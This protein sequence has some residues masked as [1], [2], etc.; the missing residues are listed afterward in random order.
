MRDHLAI[1]RFFRSP[2]RGWGALLGSAITAA[3]V[4]ITA[5]VGCGDSGVDG[6]PDSGDIADTGA[7]DGTVNPD[8]GDASDSGTATD[9]GLPIDA[10]TPDGGVTDD[11]LRPVLTGFR[12]EAAELDRLYFDSSEPIAASNTTGFFVSN[13]SATAI[14][15]NPGA[16]TGHYFTI[17][18]AFTFWDNNTIRYEGGGDVVDAYG[19]PLYEFT[20]QFV[21]N[22]IPEPAALADRYVSVSGGGAHDGTSEADAWTMAEAGSN[23]AAGQTVWMKAGDY[24]DRP[25]FIRNAGDASSPIKFIGYTTTPGDRPSLV[26]TQDTAFDAAEMPYIHSTSTSGSGINLAGQ[27]YIVLKNIQVAG[28]DHSLLANG[29]ITHVLIENVYLKDGA[30]YGFNLFAYDTHST[31]VKGCYVS[32]AGG[33]GIRVAGDHN[34]IDDMYASSRGAPSMDYYI[35]LYGGTIGLGN[36][37]RNSAVVRDPADSHTG[38]GISV[39]AGGRP[40]EHTLIEDCTLHEIGQGIEL[41]HHQ[42]RYTI[43]RNVVATGSR[44]RTANLVTFRDDTSYNTIEGCLADGIYVGVRF[45]MNAGEDLG[46]QPG[47][48]HNR[49]INTVFDNCKYGITIDGFGGTPLESTDNEFAHCTFYDMDT[50]FALPVDYGDSNTFTNCNFATITNESFN[51]GTPTTSYTY[52]NTWDLWAVV[53]GAGNISVDPMFVDAPGGDFTP[54]TADLNGGTE[55]DYVRYDFNGRERTSNR[56]RGAYETE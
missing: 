43:A 5:A 10:T 6:M 9:T 2:Q 19:N 18:E 12:V 32:N 31:R 34:L 55:L 11:G 53:P 44:A 21:D 36:I 41:R 20:L 39:K 14:T 29:N 4:L 54:G 56:T 28:Y 38:H 49:V 3:L 47:G 15:V 24:G 26:R 48:H 7:A 33:A 13:R 8:A 46:I 30:R 16:T 40:L 37:V 23:A 22:L 51:S 35:S 17:A 42:V 27:H 52:S 1:R 50:M 25:L 45:A